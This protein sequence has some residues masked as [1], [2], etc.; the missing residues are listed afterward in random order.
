MYEYQIVIELNT[1]DS[2]QLRS[3]LKNTTFPLQIS[4]HVNISDADITTGRN[5]YFIPLLLRFFLM[6]Y[7]TTFF[8][9]SKY[10]ALSK[11]LNFIQS[12]PYMYNKYVFSLFFILIFQFVTQMVP[13]TSADVR[14]NISGHIQTVLHMEPVMRSLATLVDA[15]T[16]FHP[17]GSTAS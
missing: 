16:I 14:I 8:F 12:F 15:S 4:S 13:T 7:L 6:F 2:T 10:T 11:V 1:T 3:T 9:Q 5:K 17:V